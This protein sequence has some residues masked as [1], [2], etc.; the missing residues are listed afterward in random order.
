MINCF[1]VNLIIALY[2]KW[3][4]EYLVFVFIFAITR[5]FVGGLH[6]KT[7]GVCFVV[8][9]A[10]INI[11]IFFAIEYPMHI[12]QAWLICIIAIILI[13]IMLIKLRPRDISNTQNI[14]NL[15][16]IMILIWGLNLIFTVCNMN[17]YVGLI[18]YI[19]IMLLV[20]LVLGRI[21]SFFG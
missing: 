2:M 11:T 6:F 18:S 8:S 15:K 16:K 5:S 7:Y 13:W 19:M 12:L 20:S 21:E 17:R 1:L 3:L 4:P 14:N 9:C 10:V